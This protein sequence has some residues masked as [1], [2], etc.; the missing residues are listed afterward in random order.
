M[1]FSMADAIAIAGIAV[2]AGAPLTVAILKFGR[3]GTPAD[4]VTEKLCLSRQAKIATEI[5]NLGEKID[6]LGELIREGK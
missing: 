5:K 4:V 3:N 1:I 6:N 2:G